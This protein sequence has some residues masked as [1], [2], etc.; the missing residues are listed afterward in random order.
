MP[1]RHIET[2]SP[3]S[4]THCTQRVLSVAGNSKKS[5]ELDDHYLTYP[6]NTSAGTPSSALPSTLSPSLFST[7]LSHDFSYTPLDDLDLYKRPASSP[8]P[9]HHPLPD[10]KTS[11]RQKKKDQEKFRHTDLDKQHAKLER[12]QKQNEYKQMY[13]NQYDYERQMEQYRT[14]KRQQRSLPIYC[15]TTS[16]MGL[17]SDSTTECLRPQSSTP[18]NA[19]INHSS[20]HYFLRR[21]APAPGQDA[22][23]QQRRVDSLSSAI[24]SGSSRKHLDEAEKLRSLSLKSPSTKS[25]YDL[26]PWS[27]APQAPDFEYSPG[28][29]SDDTGMSR[30]WDSLMD[31]LYTQT[32]SSSSMDSSQWDSSLKDDVDVDQLDSN[33]S[34]MTLSHGNNKNGNGKYLLVLGANG[35]TGMELVRQG[36]E[37]NYRVTAFVRDDKA[38]LE[39]SILRKNQNLLI[40]RGSPTCQADL[41]RC[42]ESQDVVINVIG[43]RF[44]TG[45]STISSHSQV[46]L[47]NAMKKHGVR[48]LIVVTSYGCHGLRNYLIA[49]K[50]LFS[51]MFMTS[52]LK[53]KVL[54]EDIIKRDSASLDWTIVRPI[55]L[56]DGDLSEKYWVSSDELPRANRVK[57]L[58]RRDLA[59]YLLGIINLPEEYHTIRSIAGKPKVS[60]VK[61]LCPFERRREAAENAKQQRELEKEQEKK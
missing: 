61:Q 24:L 35:R 4:T 3:V 56:K 13:Q 33:L 42:V 10:P 55:T 27:G 15:S 47:N 6:Y 45:D 37:R 59:H 38:L 11:Q 25:M 28:Y 9:T 22:H 31:T 8:L 58:T 36:L 16:S 54:Q 20:Q 49:T 30:G 14:E 12:K 52:I 51:H 1:M 7:Q 39:D 17:S 23:H 53:D 21:A 18:A 60:K 57:I 29:D 32:V 40:V 43:A 34:N 46:V 2:L 19:M 44:M 50:K 41:D 26:R 5:Q 48:R